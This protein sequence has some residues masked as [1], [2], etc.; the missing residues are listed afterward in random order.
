VSPASAAF[1]PDRAD[2]RFTATVRADHLLF[3]EPPRTKVRFSGTPGR[4][5]MTS[6]SRTNLPDPVVEDVDYHDVRIE[7]LLA[8]MLRTG[9]REP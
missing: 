5:S 1:D 9:P 8:T 3:R 7:Y 4:K 2:I 6:S